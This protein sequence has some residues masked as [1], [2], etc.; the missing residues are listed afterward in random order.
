MDDPGPV[1]RATENRSKYSTD[2]D[3]QLALGLGFPLN[4]RSTDKTWLS[5]AFLTSSNQSSDVVHDDDDE[6]RSPGG[7]RIFS[8][9]MG[10]GTTTV[11]NAVASSA[12]DDGKFPSVK[13]GPC[14]TKNVAEV[15]SGGKMVGVVASLVF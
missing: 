13:S 2:D 9:T 14:V 12:D 10:D 11:A 8:M 5:F 6:E 1:P 15:E 7:Q 4:S 3:H